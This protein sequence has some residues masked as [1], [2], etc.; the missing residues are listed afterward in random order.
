MTSH[1]HQVNADDDLAEAAK[2]MADKQIRRVVVVDQSKQYIG[3]VSLA[4]IARHRGD[5]DL[6]LK[7]LKGVS[8]C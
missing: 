6:A 8:C 1:I 2:V 7:A 3:I 5:E 4:D